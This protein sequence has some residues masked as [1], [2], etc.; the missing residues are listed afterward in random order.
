MNITPYT[1][2]AYYYE[3]DKMGIVHHSN[4]VRIL[5]EARVDLMAKAGLPF[6]EVEKAGLMIPV[7]SVSLDYKFPLRFDD[8]FEVRCR[9]TDFNGCKFSLKYEVWNLTTDK[10]TVSAT[11]SH[12]FTDDKLMPVRLKKKFPEIYEIFSQFADDGKEDEK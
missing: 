8:E 4:Y 1:R 11:T 7:L 3:T 12:C 5:E 6:T 10:L 2:H 9:V